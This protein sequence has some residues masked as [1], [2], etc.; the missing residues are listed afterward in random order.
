[1]TKKRLSH[2]W[3]ILV[4]IV[5]IALTAGTA[6][7]ATPAAVHGQRPSRLEWVPAGGIHFGGP[8]RASLALGALAVRSA[9][10]GN[11]GFVALAEPGFGGAKIRAGLASV[12][13]FITGFELQGALLRTFGNPG[14]RS[15]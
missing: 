9:G 14:A 12:T 6:L 5:T 7:L 3:H 8:Q 4:R 15:R 11:F 10:G 1:M 13:A 2:L